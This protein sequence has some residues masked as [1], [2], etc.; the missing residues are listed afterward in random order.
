MEEC[1]YCQTVNGT[2]GTLH[3][4]VAGGEVLYINDE[5]Q[6]EFSDKG[7]ELKIDINY[8]PM[9]GRKLEDK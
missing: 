9:C 4:D 8:C 7:S 5:A 3:V 1:K 6:L 2:R